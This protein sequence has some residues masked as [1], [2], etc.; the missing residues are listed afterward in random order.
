MKKK[1]WFKIFIGAF[2]FLIVAVIG[3]ILYLRFALPSIALEDIKAPSTPERIARGAYL[4]NHVMVCM[5]C[6]STRDWTKFSGPLVPGTIGKGGEIFDE[7]LGF[8]GSFASP[9]I[10]PFKLKDWTDAEIYR[11]ITSGVTKDGKALFPIMPY[12]YYG[13]LDKEDILSVI[14]YLRSLPAIASEVPVSEAAFPMS[15]IVNTIPKPAAMTT[16]PSPAD[17][18]AFGEYVVKAAGCV[19]CHTQA[20][21]GQIIKELAFSGG[22]EFI[23]P[24]GSALI[25]P[26]ITPDMETGI[27]RWS[28]EAFIFRFKNYDPATYTAPVLPKGSPQSI[29]PWTMYAGMDTTDLVAIYRYLHSLKPVS[30]PLARTMPV[31]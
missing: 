19:E 11:A 14:A 21:H 13:Q 31:Q 30:N 24:D 4:A 7:K 2:V 3:I 28:K 26:N 15:I 18:I 27:G 8:P 25:S 23:M 5:D 9:N 16:K 1:L 22:R 10:T 20:T 29:M 6:H 12:P 17:T